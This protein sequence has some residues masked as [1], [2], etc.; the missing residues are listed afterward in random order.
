MFC[1]DLSNIFI[2]EF[3]F[4]RSYINLSKGNFSLEINLIYNS[5]IFANMHIFMM[6]IQHVMSIKSR[7]I[8]LNR[9]YFKVNVL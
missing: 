1:F 6:H 4:K 3:N 9:Y 8:F 7:Y 5:Y 2:Y